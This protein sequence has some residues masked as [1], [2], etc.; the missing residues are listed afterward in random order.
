M[1][2]YTV[3]CPFC[4]RVE[5]IVRTI[6][7]RNE[8]MPRCHN[9]AMKRMITAPN[10]FIEADVHYTS[11][12]DGREITSKKQHLEELARTDTIV[13]EPGIKQDQERN[14]AQ[15]EQHL[16]RSVEHTVDEAI[17][18]MPAAKRERLAAELEGGL[19]AEVARI[20]PPQTSVRG[21]TN[22][23]R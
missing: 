22:G 20:T 17:T 4:L 19:V 23:R 1:P 16:E 2:T 6:D 15:R 12:V 18:I 5:D 9:R 3:L 14:A 7:K 11:P 21:G 8:D 13:Y 10:L